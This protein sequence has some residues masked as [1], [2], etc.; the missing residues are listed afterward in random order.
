M[1]TEPL[2]IPSASKTWSWMG[3]HAILHV[4]RND[5]QFCGIIIFFSFFLFIYVEFQASSTGGNHKVD[6]PKLNTTT[7]EHLHMR[8]M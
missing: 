7:I 6:V 1:R 5:N 2:Q 4:N 8:G 3:E